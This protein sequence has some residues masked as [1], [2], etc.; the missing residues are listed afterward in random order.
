VHATVAPDSGRLIENAQESHACRGPFRPVMVT[1]PP[2]RTVLWRGWRRR[3]PRCGEGRLF[4]KWLDMHERCS[5]CNLL[6]LRNQGDLWFFMIITDRVPILFG[7]AALYFGVGPRGWMTTG[8]FFAAMAIPV[9]ATLPQR[10]GLALACDFLVRV[11]M[12][13]PSDE[14]HDVTTR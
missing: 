2:L 3:C 10:Q 13:D 1:R 6:Y 12:P 9:I 7:I 5:S 11:H 14:I 4:R 8:A